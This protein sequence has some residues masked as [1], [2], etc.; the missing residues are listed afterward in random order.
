MYSHSLLL[1]WFRLGFRLLDIALSCLFPSASAVEGIKSVPSVCLSVQCMLSLKV[2]YGILS[3]FLIFHIWNEEGLCGKNTN[4]D[5]TTQEGCQRSGVFM[6]CDIELSLW[7]SKSFCKF[8]YR[9]GC[10]EYGSFYFFFFSLL[11]KWI[12]IIWYWHW[13][14]SILI[15]F[16][17]IR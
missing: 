6:Y 2:T 3:I 16:L 8:L 9:R 7:S 13:A 4:K 10:L 15:Y 12:S 14:Y 11:L 17:R 5:C 1:C